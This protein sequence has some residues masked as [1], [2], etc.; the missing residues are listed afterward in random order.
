MRAAISKRDHTTMNS[1]FPR[2]GFSKD[3]IDNH[4]P[5]TVQV[6]ELLRDAII[7][8]KLLPGAAIVEKDIC[9]ALGISRTPLRE[10]IIRLAAE[11]LVIVRPS[12]G[13]FVNLIIIHE[14]LDGQITRDT[15]EKRLVKLAARQFTKAQAGPFEIALFQQQVAADKNDIDEFFRLDNDFHKLICEC[16]GFPSGWRTLHGVTGQLDRVR[17]YALP[18]GEHCYKSLSEHQ[19]IY[20][21]IKDN[22]EDGAVAAFQNHIGRLFH[23]VDLISHLN[24]EMVTLTS[25]VTIDDIR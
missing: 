14:V 19:T 21:H 12:G 4:L 1:E 6:Y 9:E 23:E 22:D 10:A 2:L 7:S 17:R 11:S 8:M 5:K 13:T 24:P 3:Q 25:H 18:Q 16:S 15:L 20:Q